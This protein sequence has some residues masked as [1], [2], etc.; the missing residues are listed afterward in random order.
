MR[1]LARTVL[2]LAL[3]VILGACAPVQQFVTDTINRAGDDAVVLLEPGVG[4]VFDA[5]TP[6]AVQDL[7]LDIRADADLV[8]ECVSVP[9]TEVTSTHVVCAVGGV[10]AGESVTIPA[11]GLGVSVVATYRRAGSGRIFTE[12]YAGP[13]PDTE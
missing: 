10:G 1:T 13:R 11:S 12:V 2:L 7:Q 8:V 6:P 4:V 3:V 9:G 5:V